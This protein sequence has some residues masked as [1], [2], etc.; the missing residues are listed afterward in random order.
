MGQ[1]TSNLKQEDLDAL[2]QSSHF[3]QREIKKLYKRFR[4]LD[5]SGVGGL[6][7]CLFMLGF[8]ISLFEQEA[9]FMHIPELAMN[10]LSKRII[11]LFAKDSAERVDFRE[12]RFRHS[13]QYER[14]AI[15][16]LLRCLERLVR[17]LTW[18]PVCRFELATSLICWR[19]V[20]VQSLRCR[21]RWLCFPE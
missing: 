13:L 8:F 9:E 19:A 14:P 12:V 21:W 15:Y 10:P 3:N 6:S 11:A 7:V 20:C 16:S 2:E 5:R 17:V 18:P 4:K 1:S